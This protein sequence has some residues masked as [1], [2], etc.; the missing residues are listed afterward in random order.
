MKFLKY[1][2]FALLL[3]SCK[4]NVDSNVIVQEA[5]HQFESKENNLLQD[6]SRINIARI[7]PNPIEYE[8]R[9][10]NRH[11]FA[12]VQV[13]PRINIYKNF[14]SDSIQLDLVQELSKF[15][16]KKEKI[17]LLLEN[18]SEFVR[19]NIKIKDKVIHL[20]RSKDRNQKGISLNDSIIQ[21][22]ENWFYVVKNFSSE[23]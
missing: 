17:L 3:F 18:D 4:P 11:G 19:I 7:R 6:I 8:I 22:N 20:Y 9:K 23:R 2:L 15:N 13:Y 1:N 10:N 21:Y 12:I 5:I 16:N 14:I